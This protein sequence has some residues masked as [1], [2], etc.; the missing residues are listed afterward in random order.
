MTLLYWQDDESGET[1][2]VEFD[3][4]TSESH[5]DTLNITDHPVETGAN[6]TDGAREEPTRLSIEGVVSSMDNPRI[7][8]DAGVQTLVELTAPAMLNPGTQT[9]KLDPP[10]PPLEKSISGLVQAGIGALVSAIGGGPNY[11]ATFTGDPKPG[12]V[13]I[14][15]QLYPQTAGRNRIRDVYDLLLKAQSRRLLVTVQAKHREHF[16][17]LIERVAQPRSVEDGNTAKFQIDLKRI[18]VADSETVAAPKPAEARGNLGKSKG[19]QNG[20]KDPNA[21]AKEEEYASTSYKLEH[22][23]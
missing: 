11:N 20:K 23:G 10:A 6:V 15:A 19:S 22:G 7:D 2:S 12:T 8:T 16:D 9:K 14:K 13:N 1:E 17:M 5:E 21:A 3:A 18:R 4:T